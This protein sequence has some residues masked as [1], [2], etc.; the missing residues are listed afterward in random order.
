M[1]EQKT[2]R[3]SGGWPLSRT[4]AGCGIK[5]Q[6]ILKSA[7]GVCCVGTFSSAEK[8]LE[9]WLQC[10]LMS[11]SWTSICRGC[12]GLSVSPASKRPVGRACHHVTVT[13]TV[14]GFFRPCRRGR[15]LSGQVESDDVLLRAMKTSTR[16]SGPPDS[17][18][19]SQQSRPPEVVRHSRTQVP[20]QNTTQPVCL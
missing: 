20:L 7:P 2:I 6:K 16:V 5:L 12:R 1:S 14:N 10:S 17:L 15:R 4:T 3:S 13:R 9:G 11:F 8:A 19:P 18:R